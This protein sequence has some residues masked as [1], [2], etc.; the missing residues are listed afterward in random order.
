MIIPANPLA[1]ESNI[2][3]KGIFNVG[4]A[5]KPSDNIKRP[6]EAVNPG[7]DH[8]ANMPKPMAAKMEKM[9]ANAPNQPSI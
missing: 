2:Y 1:M 7:R 4:K 8:L 5:S 9:N 3:S 6:I